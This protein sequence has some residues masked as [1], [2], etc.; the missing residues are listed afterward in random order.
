MISV[1][2]ASAPWTPGN[3]GWLFAAYAFLS[4]FE[5]SEV[6]GPRC[7]TRQPVLSVP[8]V[9]AGEHRPSTCSPQAS[10][11]CLPCHRLPTA[12]PIGKA[13][14]G[15]R[16]S[17]WCIFSCRSET[18][19]VWTLLNRL[20]S[21]GFLPWISLSC[22]IRHFG[23]RFS[24]FQLPERTGHRHRHFQ[25]SLSPTPILRLVA[26][27]RVTF[28]VHREPPLTAKQV[29]LLRLRRPMR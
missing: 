7:C 10:Y 21:S 25:L 9:M 18:D 22:F 28:F 1:S 23:S 6:A 2:S 19:D 15:A 13:G 14:H 4:R 3:G 16:L 17:Y 26:A 24:K 12:L 5:V 20:L 27:E 8:T 11:V 29:V